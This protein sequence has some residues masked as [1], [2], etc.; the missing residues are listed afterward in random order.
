LRE[1]HKNRCRTLSGLE[2][3]LL[4]VAE[5]R[6]FDRDFR[7]RCGEPG[8]C[9]KTQENGAATLRRPDA[10]EL[11]SAP[12]SD[13]MR[14]PVSHKLRLAPLWPAAVALV[15]VA[16]LSLYLLPGTLASEGAHDLVAVS[17]LV[18]RG[19]ALERVPASAPDPDLGRRVRA[20]AAGTD[21]RITVIA[22]DGR[23]FAD[24]ERDETQ[25][26]A[27]DNHRGRPE[28]AAA[29]AS[30]AG[31]AVRHSDTLGRETAYAAVLATARD[32]GVFVLR[33]AR[34][35]AA[36]DTVRRHLGRSW[37]LSALAAALAVLALSWWLSR[38]LFRPLS[39]LI[40]AADDIGRGDYERRFAIPAT[41]ELATL[42]SALERIAAEAKRQIA[43]V[44][45]ER[46]HLRA[47][48]ASMAE[49]VLVTD[50]QGRPRLANPAFRELFALDG[51]APTADLL[52]LA[53]ESRLDDLIARARAGD[54]PAIGQ[55]ELLEPRSRS[56][57]LVASPLAASD[58][59]VVVARDV[60]DAERLDRMRKDFVANVSHELKTPL[61]AIQGYAETLTDGAVDERETA[62]R[63][64]Q[65]ILEQCRRLGALLDDLLTLSRLEGAASLRAP[66]PV[67][68]REV[69][70]EAVE[71]LAGA[72]A[73]R[74]VTLALEPGVALWVSGDEDALVRLAANLIDNAIK[75]NR[76]G[77]QVAV[78]LTESGGQATLEV[79]DSGIGIP[80]AALPRLF[81][82]F[83]RVDKGRAREE[84][85]TGLG[86]AIVKHVAQAHGGRV[87]VASEPGHGTR[88]RVVLPGAPPR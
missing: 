46:N 26:A 79:E 55:I 59:V 35:L 66:A 40:A 24:S 71:L 11:R 75:Y 5:G 63:F 85:G 44:E 18:E 34:P 9:R 62:L 84:G 29:L 16:S 12:E 65:R 20:L 78:R 23:V 10:A 45:A 67:D 81:E 32:G 61:A 54:T 70:A 1:L 80:A 15:V 28:V 41:T 68:L 57:A 77:G 47:T 83:Y 88:F 76:S 58:G 30:G 6:L 69:A 37:L 43:A 4:A 36:L 52:G 64:S 74:Q 13:P 73:A 48:V 17:R 31:T 42:G 50:Q 56:L 2:T 27:M 49:G 53:R 21:H 8:N 7:R 39:E 86:L 82:R 19:L 51:R 60:T 14:R 38:T 72:A 33:V 22:T 87:E 3:G 25:V